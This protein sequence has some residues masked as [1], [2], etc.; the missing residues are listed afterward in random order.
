MVKNEIKQGIVK[1]KRWS[2][3]RWLGPTVFFIALLSLIVS[4]ILGFGRSYPYFSDIDMRFFYV[5]G[6]CWWQGENPYNVEAFLSMAKTLN[7]NLE[8]PFAYPPQIAPFTL[9]LSL[10]SRPI[11]RIIMTCLNLASLGLLCVLSVR[12]V[13][14]SIKND[15]RRIQ[16]VKCCLP[17]L[18]IGNPFS[19]HVI[20]M[21][22]SSLIVAALLFSCWTLAM[23][24]KSVLAGILLGV[25]TIKP[26]FALFPMIWFILDRRW[27]LLVVAILTIIV[28]SL[29]PFIQQGFFEVLRDWFNSLQDYK[30]GSVMKIE[31]R[32]VE[33]IR[34]LL[35]SLG[36][37]APDLIGLGVL[38]SVLLWKI[39]FKISY[40][41]IF[42][43]LCGFS[44]LFV[45]AHDYDFVILVPVIGSFW[46]YNT[47]KN[48][49]PLGELILFLLICFP[50]RFLLS[51][52][53]PFLL[54][55]RG[56]FVM[57]AMVWL[58]IKGIKQHNKISMRTEPELME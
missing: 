9:F 7:F 24:G 5:A 37:N 41:N 17:A 28:L 31:H 2:L 8:P 30:I 49:L 27:R 52:D 43:L 15:D 32:H 6:K 48:K 4:G 34:S 36:F 44:I 39:K 11:A 26:Q 40:D 51:L 19:S 53:Q 57:V 58:L 21:G 45:Y 10:W 14:P 1:V 47:N 55:F 20:W 22:Q 50:Q 38:C 16:F 12:Q 56:G 18:I 54:H 35:W 13:I 42:P 25:S 29:L 46:F 33:G 3:D 23:K